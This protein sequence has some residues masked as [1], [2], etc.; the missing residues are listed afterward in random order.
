MGRLNKIF[1]DIYCTGPSARI[2]MIE[3]MLGNKI[4]KSDIEPLTWA[5]NEVGKHATVSE[6]A[7]W[8]AELGLAM[9]QV[10]YFMHDNAYD[11]LISPVTPRIAPPLGYFDFV[12]KDPLQGLDRA[13]EYVQFTW[14]HNLTGMPAISLP[15]FWN[16]NNLP[17]GVQFAAKVGNEA[18]LLQLGCQ[19]ESASPWFNK[20]PSI[21]Q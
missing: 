13:I 21:S 1:K 9:R 14:L 12:H 19:L 2:D 17:V 16:K 20:I 7:A 10:G 3:T 4:D 11:L 6:L 5:M 15:V 8:K 18:L